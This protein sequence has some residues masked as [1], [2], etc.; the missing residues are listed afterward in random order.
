ISSFIV[1]V[2]LMVYQVEN[3]LMLTLTVL[4]VDFIPYVGVGA[5]FIPWII[6]NFFTGDYILTIQLAVLYIVIIVVRQMIEPRILASSVG[7]HPLFALIILFIGIQSLGIVGIFITPIVLITISA[8]YH[9]G[10]FH[11]IWYYIKNG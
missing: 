8:I 2:G 5:V 1:M 9:A 11:F 3:V 6:Y 7:I 10:I 4:F